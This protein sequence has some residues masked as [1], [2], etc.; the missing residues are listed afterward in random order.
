MAAP[1]FGLDGLTFERGL[2]LLATCDPIYKAMLADLQSKK[3]YLSPLNY[4]TAIQ[5]IVGLGL[6]ERDLKRFTR[7]GL[8]QQVRECSGFAIHGDNYPDIERFQQNIS[9]ITECV[10]DIFQSSNS[11]RDRLKFYIVAFYSPACFEAR[12]ETIFEFDLQRH[13]V[14]GLLKHEIT[15][16]QQLHDSYGP[17]ELSDFMTHLKRNGFSPEALGIDSANPRN[18]PDIQRL[19]RAGNIIP[20]MT[21]IEKVKSAAYVY[22]T[23]PNP[24]LMGLKDYIRRE[25]GL[26]AAELNGLDHLVEQ[27]LEEC[28]D[29]RSLLQPAPAATPAAAPATAITVSA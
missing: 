25:G 23:E 27:F 5:T 13:S 17:I 14:F 19:E 20:L 8:T 2:E 16:F 29:C 11:P 10:K 15:L 4:R 1:S 7:D 24:T 12:A 28:P 18:N 21:A 6:L 9:R 22:I 3:E 26:T